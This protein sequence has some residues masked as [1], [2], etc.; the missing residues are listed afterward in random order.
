MSVS[1]LL[2]LPGG[3]GFVEEDVRRVVANCPKQR[4]LLREDPTQCA[5]QLMIRANQGHSM[6][7][8]SIEYLL[9]DPLQYPLTT[10]TE[11]GSQG[12]G[13]GGVG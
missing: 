9:Q 7:V 11:E 2:A 6:E 4:F 1:E 3:R 8:R 5:G 13:W 10:I 12:W